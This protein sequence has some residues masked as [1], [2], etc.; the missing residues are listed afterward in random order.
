MM[1][2]LCQEPTE[3]LAGRYFFRVFCQKVPQL[4]FMHSV[5][6]H[7]LIHNHNHNHTH[8]QT[9]T[10]HFFFFSPLLLLL[11]TFIFIYGRKSCPAGR[12]HP[13]PGVDVVVAVVGCCSFDFSYSWRTTAAG[14]YGTVVHSWDRQWSDP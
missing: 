6:S 5:L 12:P 11:F 10:H 9:H 14:N 1:C 7:T 3:H 8:T 2:A 4:K 13:W